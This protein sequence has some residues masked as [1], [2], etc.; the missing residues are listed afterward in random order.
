MANWQVIAGKLQLFQHPGADKLV[1]GKVGPFQIVFSKDN[2]YSDGDVIFFAPEKSILPDEIKSEYCN[3]ETGVSYLSGPEQN[4]VKRI[5]LRGEYSEGV[6]LN[7][8]WACNKLGLSR[9]EVP[10]NED[11]SERL[12][13]FKFEPPLPINM[14]GELERIEN[15]SHQKQHD[16]EQIRLYASEF[17]DG[18]GLAF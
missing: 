10:L 4:R 18:E 11:L 14:A 1:L 17:I 5:R 12:G 13:I 2:G 9:N 7:P 8:E 6:T 15:I 3:T 16:C